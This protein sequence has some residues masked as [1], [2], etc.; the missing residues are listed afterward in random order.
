V[1]PVLAQIGPFTLYTY[2]VLIDAGLAVALAVLYFQAPAGK[3]WRWLDLGLAAMVGG[4]I[5]ARLVYISVNADYYLPHIDE[6]VQVWQGGLSWLG[7]P[8][9]AVLGAWLYAR[10]QHEALWPVLDALALPFGL[11]SL[12]G[13]S[14]C[15]V[16]GCAYGYP[17]APG[18]LPGW[19]VSQTPDIFGIVMPRFPTQ[20]LGIAWSVVALL[21]LWGTRRAPATRWPVGAFG[22]YALSLAALGVFGLS[23]T[24]GDPAPFMAGYRIDVVGGALVLVA[25]TVAWTV[26]LV[27]SAPVG[28][29][30]TAAVTSVPT[31]D[32]TTSPDPPAAGAA[33]ADPAASS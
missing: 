22:A 6:V 10:R 32:A 20:A 23:F 19:F 31:T 24:R 26:R 30:Q 14:G 12:L 5:G 3:A 8:V 21:A 7:A 15:L 33:P 16:A 29:G 25:A 4:F 11:L 1:H 17:V 9:G 27:R 28:A 2:T 13:W 18:Q